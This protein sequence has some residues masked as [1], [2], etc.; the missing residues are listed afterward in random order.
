ME[1]KLADNIRA[2]RKKM[3]LTQE[4]LAEVI[5]VTAGAVYKWEA[6]LSY[7]EL[8]LIVKMADFFDTS[9]DVLLG[10]ELKDNR[11]SATVQRLKDY[12]NDKN[13]VGMEEAEKALKKY[14][15]SFELVHLSAFIYWRF[16][17]ERGDKALARRALELME[18]S[19]LLVSQNADPEISEETIC[20]KIAEIMMN[21]GDYE[22]SIELLKKHNSG[23]RY[24]DKIGLTLSTSAERTEE[25][26]TFLSEALLNIVTSFTQIVS[27]YTHVYSHKKDYAALK[28]LLLWGSG[29][30]TSLSREG[31][32]CFLDKL[33]AGL[34]VALAG[35]ELKLGRAD[36]A[37]ARLEEAYKLAQRFD[38]DPSYDPNHVRFV[39]IKDR[40]SVYDSLG[41]TAGE[42]L[43]HLVQS[44][45]EQELSTL[46]EEVKKDAE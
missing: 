22:K 44:M 28:E 25:A 29:F 5:G 27:G 33:N 12:T 26:E 46:W 16:A 43:D 36:D 4:Q 42:G 23:G 13:P 38:E 19:L 39:S 9:V 11:L 1:I 10:Y 37:R 45:K 35:T 24:N 2:W 8:N 17:I 31:Q 15:H 20:G 21:L 34:L 3:S 14:P 32:S 18:Q 40:S 6:Q 7:P 30:L 41:T